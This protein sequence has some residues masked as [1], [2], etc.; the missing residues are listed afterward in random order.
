[1]IS[2]TEALL[3]KRAKLKAAELRKVAALEAEIE[4]AV[5]N[6]MGWNGIEFRTEEIN[7]HVIA[8]VNYR[9]AKAGWSPSWTMLQKPHPM[10]QRQVVVIGFG[11]NL[12]PGHE[13]YNAAR[14]A[15]ES[16]DGDGEDES[17][18]PALPP[19]EA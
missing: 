1:M 8:E 6:H 18:V 14:A 16:S 11:L 5:R 12:N 10:N 9:L 19:A 15:L 3:L 17:D 2:A 4:A 13:A 7:P